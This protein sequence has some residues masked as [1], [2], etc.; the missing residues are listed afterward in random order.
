MGKLRDWLLGDGARPRWSI[1][2]FAVAAYAEDLQDELQVI[3][4]PLRWHRFSIIELAEWLAKRS[5]RAM[6]CNKHTSA[7]TCKGF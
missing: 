4:T 2:E 7:H 5:R 6:L 1:L 3:R